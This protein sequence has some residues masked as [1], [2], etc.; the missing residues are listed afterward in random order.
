MENPDGTTKLFTWNSHTEQLTEG[1]TLPVN[2]GA[3]AY[4]PEQDLLY[5]QDRSDANYMHKL[6]ANSGELLETSP[7]P[8]KS[9]ASWD[10]TFCQY[11][12]EDSA[13]SVFATYLCAPGKLMDNNQLMGVLN[14]SYYLT[15]VTHANYLTSVTSAG[16]EE[17]TV[18]ETDE[19]GNVIGRKPI[20]QN[21]STCWTIWGMSGQSGC[22]QPEREPTVQHWE[23]TP[24]TW[25][26]S[27]PSPV[28]EIL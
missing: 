4:D 16:V 1:A 3:A 17:I 26:G 28:R 5:V 20:L 12:G 13:V 2:V 19:E 14:L 8:A 6:Q 22:T 23:Y 9:V 21:A 10:M 25:L 7:D 15:W 11:L 27:C 24:P 18:D